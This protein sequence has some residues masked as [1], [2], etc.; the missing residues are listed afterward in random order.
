MPGYHISLRPVSVYADTGNRLPVTGFP[1]DRK[2]ATGDNARVPDFSSVYLYYINLLFSM[3]HGLLFKVEGF[4][5][6]LY[7]E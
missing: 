7:K 4:S 6:L 1:G 3:A 5:S 2:L